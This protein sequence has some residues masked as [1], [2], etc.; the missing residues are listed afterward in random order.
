[1]LNST[2]VN[3]MVF[4]RL[5]NWE[6]PKLLHPTS[7]GFDICELKRLISDEIKLDERDATLVGSAALIGAN[8]TALRQRYIQG[9][10]D[11][12]SGQ[13]I[14]SFA[15]AD[16]NRSWAILRQKSREAHEATAAQS[17]T[18]YLSTMGQVQV[19]VGPHTAPAEVDDLNTAVIDSLPHWFAQA[20]AAPEDAAAEAFD[21]SAAGP[22]A[23][24]ALSLE[25]AFREIWQEILWEPWTIEP[26]ADGWFVAPKDFDDQALW[27]VWSWREQAL[28]L[29]TSILNRH[30]DRALPTDQLPIILPRTAIAI[31]NCEHGRRIVIG[32]PREEQAEGHRSAMENLESAYVAPFL[33]QSLAGE[34]AAVTPR[35]PSAGS[36][37]IAGFGRTSNAP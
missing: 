20:V 18:G 27:R 35:T 33:D 26:A 2:A 12:L 8:L 23:Q 11:G 19:D 21:F 7:A 13:E 5:T 15:V 22:R 16:A 1:M 9:T 14:A 25:H 36:L 31:E 10:F 24:G 29:Q 4:R 37:R 17:S 3:S 34:G 30:F 6:K 32:A 28:F